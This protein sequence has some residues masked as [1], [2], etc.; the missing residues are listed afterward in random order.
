M[1]FLRTAYDVLAG[2]VVRVILIQLLLQ[3]R[4]LSSLTHMFFLR[5]SNDV[6][7]R[8]ILACGGLIVVHRWVSDRLGQT[9][10]TRG[11]CRCNA[12]TRSGSASAG[13]CGLISLGRRRRGVFRR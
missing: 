13:M 8:L 7:L 4:L 1:L 6:A 11:A 5:T 10:S 2:R 3:V 12:G 9:G